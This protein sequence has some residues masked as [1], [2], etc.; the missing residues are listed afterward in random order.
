MHRRGVSESENIML[1][2]LDVKLNVQNIE[3]EEQ[4]LTQLNTVHIFTTVNIP[5]S[6]LLLTS[7]KGE[8]LRLMRL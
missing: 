4:I 3:G 1:I 7:L 6:E 5:Q 2:T 8:D